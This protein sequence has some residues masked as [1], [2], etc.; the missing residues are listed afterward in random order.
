MLD[1]EQ[2][3]TQRK[4][5]LMFPLPLSLLFLIQLPLLLLLPEHD[6]ALAGRLPVRVS[7]KEG[8]I[9]GRSR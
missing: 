3:N 4:L 6:E 7:P 2:Q 1:A 8:G 5:S 9:K